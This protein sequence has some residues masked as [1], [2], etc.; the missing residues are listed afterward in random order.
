LWAVITGGGTVQR[1][2]GGVT[3]S[4]S[5][6]NVYQV[7]FSRNVTTCA[8][9][10]TIGGATTDI[11]APGF[12][13]PTQLNANPNTVQVNTYD[14]AGNGTGRSFHLIVAC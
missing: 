9:V 10:A 6:G 2:S 14:A 5:G 13:I 3:A 1:S 4:V 7:T 11:P 8:Y 12:A